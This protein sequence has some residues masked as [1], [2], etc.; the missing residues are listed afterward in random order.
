[1]PLLLGDA[2]FETLT[3]AAQAA[4]KDPARLT[5]IAA[6][7]RLGTDK[8]T[9]V[10]QGLL[11]RTGEDETQMGA[12]GSFTDEQLGIDI[13]QTPDLVTPKLPALRDYQFSLEP[14]APGDFD[15]AAATRGEALFAGAA[16]CATC[17]SGSSFTDAPTLHEADEI[18]V[19]ATEAERSLT[20]QYRTTPLRG[21]GSRPP[22][23]HD[24][25]AQTL[26]DVVEH[27]DTYLI[28]DLT[29]DQRDDLVEYLKSL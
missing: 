1:M 13:V 28:L 4:G 5:A 22:Y 20:G 25:S 23:F 11:D 19:D 29:S 24:G 14:P 18:G 7:G 21:V 3:T 12:H 27:Y 16:G 8:A 10:L 17:H 26:L 2:R 9:S 15:A 6:L